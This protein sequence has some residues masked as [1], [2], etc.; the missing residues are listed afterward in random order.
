MIGKDKLLHEVLSGDGLF[1]GHCDVAHDVSATRVVV[2]GYQ[3]LCP[4]AELAWLDSS[5]GVFGA[6]H[7]VI[8][9]SALR[10]EFGSSFPLR[11]PPI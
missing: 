1:G 6:M 2:Y 11:F 7:V 3:S 10:G 9:H 4:L 5:F 8:E